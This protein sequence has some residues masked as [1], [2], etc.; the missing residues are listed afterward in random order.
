MVKKESLIVQFVYLSP[1]PSLSDF[2]LRPIASTKFSRPFKSMHSLA[3][4]LEGPGSEH[5]LAKQPIQQPWTGPPTTKN[6]VVSKQCA[7]IQA[8]VWKVPTTGLWAL[9][10]QGFM[11]V[12]PAELKN[13]PEKCFWVVDLQTN[14]VRSSGADFETARIEYE[15]FISQF[16]GQV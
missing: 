7:L 4:Y 5:E 2:R 15:E 3:I 14:R 11:L 6:P 8:V 12:E 1:K 9:E 13:Q 16:H 10:S